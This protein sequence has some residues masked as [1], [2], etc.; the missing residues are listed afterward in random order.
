MSRELDGGREPRKDPASRLI[1]DQEQA[2]KL[3]DPL[4]FGPERE[5]KVDTPKQRRPDWKK[6]SARKVREATAPAEPER[7]EE[8]VPQGDGH[9]S[10]PQA[11]A[12]PENTGRPDPLEGRADLFPPDRAAEP[13]PP[14]DPREAPSSRGRGRTSPREGP[15]AR[16][17]RCRRSDPDD[18]NACCHFLCKS[19]SMAGKGRT[20]RAEKPSARP[21]PLC[22]PGLRSRTIPRGSLRR[23]H[24]RESGTWLEQTPRAAVRRPHPQADRGAAPAGRPFLR[25][26]RSTTLRKIARQKPGAQPQNQTFC[27]LRRT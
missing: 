18:R 21:R 2:G 17:P 5:P 6:A 9:Q 16:L 22:A 25:A 4:R 24:R 26:A 14:D 12:A 13:V 20:P 10:A 23:R 27:C 19:S 7:R 11:G 8:A 15:A 3:S 1:S